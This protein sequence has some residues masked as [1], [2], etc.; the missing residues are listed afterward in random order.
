MPASPW[1][2]STRTAATFGCRA[3]ATAS[4]SPYGRM[5]KPG[6]NGPKPRRYW[7][8]EEKPTIV[9]VRPWKLSENTR[10]SASPSGTPLIS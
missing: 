6:A 3:A 5:R 4:A 10:I 2:G 1:I 9:V 8:S 7:G